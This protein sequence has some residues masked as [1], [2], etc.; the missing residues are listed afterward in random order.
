MKKVMMMAMMFMASSM[1]FAGDSDGL[2]AV[3]KA[4]TYAEAE[5][6]LKQNLG[7]MAND[8]E[9][10][11]AYNKL[12]D[13]AM[14]K[15]SGESKKVM[16]IKTNAD[17]GKKVDLTVDSIG[18][19]EAFINAL[20][21]AV[22]CN[23]Y[24]QMPNAK[25]KVAPKFAEK[26]S[27]RIWVERQNLLIFGDIC[28]EANDY[29]NCLK[30]WIPWLDSYTE[31]LFAAQEH[32]GEKNVV[33]QV[34]Y[35]SAWMANNMKKS[36]LAIKYAKMALDGKFKTEAERILMAAMTANLKTRAD[37]LKYIDQ[38][39]EMMAQEPENESIINNL[40]QFYGEMKDTKA[41]NELLDGILAKNP[42][43]FIALANKGVF[44][45]NS[46]NFPT[47][48]DYLRKAIAVRQDNPM[49]Y[50]FLG[51][52]LCM[53]AQEETAP[54]NAKPEVK[55]QADAKKKEL[56]K[57]AVEI[58]DRCKLLDPDKQQVRWGYNR[59]NAY[60]NY[61]GPDSPEYKAAEADYKN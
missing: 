2:K 11:K 36:D 42:Q 38:L 9:K 30:Y 23:K 1:A 40:Y 8:E 35:L 31:P 21:A 19:R 61:Y 41:Q 49:V 45:Y 52:S 43:N 33:E 14:Q 3:M 25:G 54:D 18:F 44:A 20:A 7:Q 24:D 46:N 16:E 37:S 29:D 26:N 39:K 5:Q 27:L 58:F 15:V 48:I 17:F 10:A 28:R 56:Y 55:K 22:E 57:E 51:T 50:F 13:L 59:Q 12:V 53:Q 4:K 6:L 32:T 47:A 60:Y 34:S